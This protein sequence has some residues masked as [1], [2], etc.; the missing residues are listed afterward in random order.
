[1]T[2]EEAVKFVD[3]FINYERTIS[4]EYPEAFKLDRMSALAKE[5]GNPQKSFESILIA[6]S[7]GKGSVAAILSS[8]LRMDDLRVGLYTSPHLVSVRERIQVNGL[9]INET[10]FIEIVL[11]LRKI[12]EDYAWRKNPPTYFEI[13]TAM[14]FY[15]FKEMKVQV[16]VLEVGLGGIYDSTNIVEAKVAGIAPISLEHTDKLGKTVSKIAVQKCG[17]IKGREAVVSAPQLPEVASVIE[18]TAEEKEAK[19]LIVGKDIKIFER[20]YAEEYQRFDIRSSVGNYFNLELRLLGRHQIQNAALAIGLAKS[21]ETKTR[22]KISEKAVRQ[23]ILDVGWPGR[24][25][26]LDNAKVKIVLDGAHNPESMKR[27]V[28]GLKRHFVFEKLITVLGIS[29]DKDLEGIVKELALDTFIF[30]ATQTK[31]PRALAARAVAETIKA[32]SKKVF[33]EE[34]P[35]AALQKAKSIA[36]PQDLILVTGSLFLLGELKIQI[37]AS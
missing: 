11:L 13:L 10:R 35:L 14:A 9:P 31:N 37:N 34:E 30:I 3:S 19:L 15:Y 23:G 6:G 16:A 4:W 22:L 18:K 27:L 7:K 2:Y 36:G 29:A 12:L 25:E 17:I 28:E 33:V 8:I 24:M 5:L 32:A 21:L 26:V 1:M 20:E